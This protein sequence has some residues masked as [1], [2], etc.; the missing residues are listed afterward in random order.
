MPP[1]P[2]A[3]LEILLLSPWLPWPPHDGARIRIDATLRFLARRNRVTLVAPMFSPREQESIATLKQHCTEVHA[4]PMTDTSTARMG[5]LATGA[6]SGLPPIQSFYR[7]AEMARRVRELT[8]K[9]R[10]DVVQVE[11]SFLAHYL[12]AVSPACGAR[13]ILSMH[14]V[15]SLRFERELAVA[16]WNARRLVVLAD[17]YLFPKWEQ[18]AVRAADGLVAVSDL[19]AQW[20]RQ[21]APSTPIRIVNNG[22]DVDLY[23]PMPEVRPQQ[24]IVFTGAMDYPPNIDAAVWF[25][26]EIWPLVRARQPDLRFVI[27][28]R[29]PTSQ[30]QRL[31]EVPG[32]IVTGE[33]P[34]MK[35][36]IAGS[37]ALVVPLR[38]GG[39][40]RLKILQAMAMGRPVVSTTLGAE[41]LEVRNGENI[42]IADEPA[43]FVE[44][45]EKLA[46]TPRLGSYIGDAGRQLVLD[47]YDWQ[48]CLQGLEDL[49]GSVLGGRA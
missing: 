14:N 17:R 39:G 38:S 27:A 22:V 36:H 1:E 21:V 33:L 34:D 13:T 28:G 26:Q 7:S 40:T 42:L 48:Q 5:R 24:Q 16:A 41:G 18:Q 25:T 32:V 11:F 45:L 23:Q 47:R 4:I 9:K 29:K 31:S 2:S 35:P 19:E 49:Y 46:H 3:R 15:E 44:A 37:L 8:A 6:L 30:V 43:A 10:F 20:L 12:R